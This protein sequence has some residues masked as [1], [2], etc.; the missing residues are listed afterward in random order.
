MSEG[1]DNLRSRCLLL[2]IPKP[3]DIEISNVLK[4]VVEKENI[5]IKDPKYYQIVEES[6][7]NLRRAILL[8]QHYYMTQNSN[9]EYFEN[10]KHCISNNIVGTSFD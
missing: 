3:N 4:N 10:W 6:K 7:G 5:N 9:E 2:R 1:V 8:M